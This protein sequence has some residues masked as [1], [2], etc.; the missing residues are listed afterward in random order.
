MGEPVTVEIDGQASVLILKDVY[1]KARK[2]FEFSEMPPDEAYAA[3]EQ[4]WGDDSGL[5]ACQDRKGWGA[6]L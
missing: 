5:D 2:N 3:V 4:A 6:M 1:K